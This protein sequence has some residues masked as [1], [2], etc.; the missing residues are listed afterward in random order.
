MPETQDGEQ[1][2]I[3]RNTPS[4]A[5]TPL[6]DHGQPRIRT[7]NRTRLIDRATDELIG[8]CRGIAADGVVSVEEARFFAKWM[9]RNRYS[10]ADWP[11]SI[12]F[13]RIQAMLEDEVM[14]PDEHEEP[15]GLLRAITGETFPTDTDVA[16][17]STTLPLADPAPSIVFYDQYF[18]FTGRFAF[19]TR[20]Q[21]E[22]AVAERGGFTQRQPSNQ[23]A[24]LVIGIMGST[25]WMH[26]THG[27]KIE[28]ALDLQRSGR[29]IALVSEQHW[30]QEV[31][32]VV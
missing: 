13:P 19:G 30:S 2:Y 9:E 22:A 4:T 28:D 27:R 15:L 20:R 3:L 17:Y 1:I 18:C 7:F 23:T 32:A 5:S 12:L 21:C 16:S 6:D 25:D 29:S 24:Y 8:L 11:G 31:E 14:D 10:R 26:S